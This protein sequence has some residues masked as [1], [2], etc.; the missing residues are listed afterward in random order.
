M[1]LAYQAVTTGSQWYLTLH[2]VL[3][4]CSNA[5][6]LPISLADNC[7]C[8]LFLSPLLEVKTPVLASLIL[9]SCAMPYILLEFSSCI[10]QLCRSKLR[11]TIYNDLILSKISHA[12]I[13]MYIYS[14]LSII[15]F[16]LFSERRSCFVVSLFDMVVSL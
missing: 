13:C 10:L 4:M 14:T 2:E 12:P 15:N 6:F 7:H 3:S 5:I 16:F 11:H 1:R 8:F 9:L